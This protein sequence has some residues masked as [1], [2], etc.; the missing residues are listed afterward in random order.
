MY[1]YI[2]IDI[3]HDIFKSIVK[4][5]NNFNHTYPYPAFLD[6][7]SLQ[8]LSTPFAVEPWR[9]G[10]GRQVA[11]AAA[12]GAWEWH[13]LQIL[14]RHMAE[15]PITFW[16][17]GWLVVWLV[18][19]VVFWLWR[20]GRFFGIFH[21]SIEINPRLCG[22]NKVMPSIESESS[23]LQ[24]LRITS[25]YVPLQNHRWTNIHQPF[26][27]F[28]PTLGGPIDWVP[29]HGRHVRS[30]ASWLPHMK[31]PDKL[32]DDQWCLCFACILCWTKK[33]EETSHSQHLTTVIEFPD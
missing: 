11:R 23:H 8:L 7:N 9:H 18:G 27:A 16:L 15:I 20:V 12:K 5:L 13:G 6:I 22:I 17:V 10:V 3:L 30:V 26:R 2:C 21:G 28:P 1:I 29:C 14:R 32:D 25:S 24:Q 33:A 4:Q 19:W 31:L